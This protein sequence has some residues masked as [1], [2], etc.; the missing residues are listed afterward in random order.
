MQ[1]KPSVKFNPILLKP[2]GNMRSQVVFMGR[3]IGS[4]SARDYMLSK[5]AELL[6]RP[7]RF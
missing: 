2:E 1:K 4:V 5:K 7:S 3:P 6:K